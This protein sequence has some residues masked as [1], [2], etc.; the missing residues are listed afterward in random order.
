VS[1][2]TVSRIAADPFMRLRC[3][4]CAAVE[5]IPDP[6][7]WAFKKSLLLAAQPGWSEAWE[8]AQAAGNE[9]PGADPAVITDGMILAAVQAVRSSEGT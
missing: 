2:L 4:A 8:S 9:Q 6:E 5:R 7:N 1:Y 3:G